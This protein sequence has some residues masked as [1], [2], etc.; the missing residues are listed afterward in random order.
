MDGKL[1]RELASKI[2][3]SQIFRDY[4]RA[5]SETTHLPLA[6]R[7][8][9]SWQLAQH[10]QK[11]ENP[12]C[13]L[14]ARSSRSCAM[15]LEMQ[16]RVGSADTGE[17]KTEV[18][19]AGLYD[20][21]VPVKLGSEILGF[22]Q[23]GQVALRKPTPSQFKKLT[24]QLLEWGVTTDL[25]E[26]EEAYFHTHV[27]SK[28]QYAS[29]LR[30]LEV[31]ARHLALCAEQIAVQEENAEAPAIRKA[32]AFIEEHKQDQLS[33]SQVA[34]SVNVSTYHFCKM[35]KRATGFTFTEYLSLVR[36]AKAKNLLLN[37]HLHVSEIAYEVGFNSLTHFN[38]VF[39]K[40]VGQS[41]SAYRA[42]F[43]GA[44]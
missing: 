19:L 18:C 29:M 20:S 14:L 38:R 9:E 16:D 10:G 32:K 15:C 4:Q 1:A 13:A 30:L 22:L 7:T 39:K 27:L 17:T 33:L 31:F 8:S 6:F 26:L 25:K 37:P 34:R 12:F 23:T 42:G 36:I 21:A 40:I 28:E 35:F 5:F 3:E 41:P 44:R 2:A 24:R 43:A 11:Y